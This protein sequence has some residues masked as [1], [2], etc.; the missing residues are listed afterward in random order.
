MA[1]TRGKKRKLTEEAA[2]SVAN[3]D[4]AVS[5]PEK[6][7]DVWFEDGNLVVVAEN[8][9]FKVYRGILAQ[10]SEI[11]SDMLTLPQPADASTMDGCLVVHV[12][13][14]ATDIKHVM[15]ALFNSA[16]RYFSDDHILSFE[17]ISAMLRLGFKYNITHVRE[18]AIRR[19]R[20]CF[21]SDLESFATPIS[22]YALMIEY[23]EEA[24]EEDS[25]A[26]FPQ[27]STSLK[28]YDAFAVIKLARSFDLNDILPAAFYTCAQMDNASVASTPLPGDEMYRLSDEDREACMDGQDAL[29]SA[30]LRS[31]KWLLRGPQKGCETLEKCQAASRENTKNLWGNAIGYCDALIDNA[32]IDALPGKYCRV[33]LR[34]A[35]REY[36]QERVTT[37]NKLREYFNLPYPQD[38]SGDVDET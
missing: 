26:Y 17:E 34:R 24:E 28:N 11:F 25:P 16:I 15:Y 21:P 35:K 6:S 12:S 3:D 10:H 19:L 30:M 37:W 31:F 14:S 32:W 20:R 23:D 1:N 33:C 22:R 13:D 8:I 36:D 18:E 5:I 4:D 27:S 2:P 7:T 9:G 38:S 29:R